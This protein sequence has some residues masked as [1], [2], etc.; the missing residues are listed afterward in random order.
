MDPTHK[1][2]PKSSPSTTTTTKP[3][4]TPPDPTTFSSKTVQNISNHFS[5]LYSNHKAN[6]SLKP[7]SGSPHP[8]P[9]PQ[10]NKDTSN[11]S[12]IKS[13]RNSR[14]NSN[15]LD[16]GSIKKSEKYNLDTKRAVTSHKTDEIK[17]SI[18][19][20]QESEV[21][22]KKHMVMVATK[23]E[24]TPVVKG[25]YEMKR[26]YVSLAAMNGGG[27]RRSSFC[28]SQKELADFLSCNGVKVVSVDMPPFMQIHAVDCARKTY[29]SLE[30]FT[31]KT[32]ASTLKKVLLFSNPKC[33]FGTAYC[34]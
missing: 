10:P 30:K 15:D 20:D 33:L 23:Q 28:S 1:K 9:Q 4:P 14:R 26:P 25:V 5:R 13:D 24:T 27:G 12:S 7:S 8:Q 18:E 34:T 32:L 31:A 19:K 22:I 2:H 11:S 16:V 6:A 21:D 17:K 3:H 29:D